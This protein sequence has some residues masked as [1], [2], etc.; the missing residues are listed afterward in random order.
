MAETKPKTKGKGTAKRT[1]PADV[2]KIIKLA[3]ENPQRGGI[4]VVVKETGFTVATINNILKKNGLKGDPKPK[5]KGK[6][7][8]IESDLESRTL[9]QEIAQ[10]RTELKELVQR[11]L[12]ISVS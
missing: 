9:M 8:P 11:F 10:K 1:T 12:H 5:V 6:K 2:E 3:K 4:Q 7:G